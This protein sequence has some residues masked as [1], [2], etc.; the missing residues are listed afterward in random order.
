MNKL[1]IGKSVV[2]FRKMIKIHHEIDG[3][4]EGT[5]KSGRSL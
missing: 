4:Q 3:K 5:A 1:F 2:S